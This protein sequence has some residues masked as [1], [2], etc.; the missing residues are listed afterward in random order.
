[1]TETERPQRWLVDHE[2]DRSTAVCIS[3]ER[4][5]HVGENHSSFRVKVEIDFIDPRDLP[6]VLDE[7]LK[8]CRNAAE[9]L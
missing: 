7:T 6:G 1:M 9:T 5:V 8:R 3:V 2:P 4:N